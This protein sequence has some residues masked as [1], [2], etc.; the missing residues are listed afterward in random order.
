MSELDFADVRLGQVDGV[1]SWKMPVFH[2]SRGR[3]FKAYV[4]G[5]LGSFPIPFETYEHFFTESKKNV[6][7][8]MHFQQSP[9][10]AKKI[11]SLVKGRADVFLLDT[12]VESS[13][14][15]VVH[16]ELFDEA[17]PISIF[18]PTGVALGYLILTEGTTI[19][20]RMDVA[21]CANCDAGIDP[22]V[23]SRFLQISIDETIR[24]ERDK[25]LNSFHDDRHFS[26]C[27][28]KM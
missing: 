22:E 3:L 28:K 15:G 6:F 1:Q 16:K 8:G 13:T 2:D 11:V 9:H 10:A 27:L 7:R 21:F 24:S 18:I 20:Y 19:S 12:R 14:Y 23:I 17:T 25:L 4:A 26:D 5:E